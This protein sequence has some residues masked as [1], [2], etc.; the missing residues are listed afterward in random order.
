MN[1]KLEVLQQSSWDFPNAVN[2]AYMNSKNWVLI[3]FANV[4]R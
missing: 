3:M 1:V 4:V 2:T